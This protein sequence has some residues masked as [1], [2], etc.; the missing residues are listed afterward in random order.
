MCSSVLTAL[1]LSLLIT[2][3]S[4]EV[5]WVGGGVQRNFHCKVQSGQRVPYSQTHMRVICSTINRRYPLRSLGKSTRSKFSWN[6][7]LGKK[8]TACKKTGGYAA[9]LC[10]R[11]V[12]KS[13]RVHSRWNWTAREPVF[14]ALFFIRLICIYSDL[15]HRTIR[16]LKQFKQT[17]R[18]CIHFKIYFVQLTSWFYDNRSARE[19]QIFLNRVLELLQPKPSGKSLHVDLEPHVIMSRFLFWKSFFDTLISDDMYTPMY[20]Y[21]HIYTDRVPHALMVKYWSGGLSG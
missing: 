18:K 20:I 15:D 12:S 17:F 16:C 9:C 3:V 19:V 1:E 13:T 14:P 11:V 8:F 5:M 4:V 10:D 6:R 7:F 2:E 21:I